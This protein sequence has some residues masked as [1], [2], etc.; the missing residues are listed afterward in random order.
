MDYY[1]VLAASDLGIFPSYYEPWG[2]TPLESIAYAV[3]TITTDQTGFGLW[4]RNTIGE[5]R[6][7]II[8][9]RS[10]VPFNTIIENL[11]GILKSFIAWSDEEMAERRREARRAAAQA[12]WIKFYDRYNEAYGKAL[13]VARTRTASFDSADIGEKK[14]VFAGTASMQ[15]HF[16]NLTAVVNLPREIHRIREMAY[17]MWWTWNPE[18]LELVHPS[19]S[20][21]VG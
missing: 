17:N 16:R 21:I 14:H 2:Y 5:N 10:G 19:R 3:P 9:K 12:A 7:V 18:A 8:L 15:P 11:F 1:N 4:V 20:E 6:G 13:A